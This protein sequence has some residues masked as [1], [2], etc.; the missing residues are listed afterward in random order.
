MSIRWLC[1]CIAKVGKINTSIG[2]EHNISMHKKYKLKSGVLTHRIKTRWPL[3]S[4]S[5]TFFF[6]RPVMVVA[7]VVCNIL[8]ACSY[9]HSLWLCRRNVVSAS[10]WILVVMKWNSKESKDSNSKDHPE[11]NSAFPVISRTNTSTRS[12]LG[13]FNAISFIVLSLL[14]T[15][16]HLFLLKIQIQL[17]TR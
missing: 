3:K 16:C 11:M 9:Y 6:D 17:A 5:F 1:L 13:T 15:N 12:S 7:F 10:V 8:L 4:I 14:R 2:F